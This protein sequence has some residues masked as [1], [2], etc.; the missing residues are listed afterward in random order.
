METEI[1]EQPKKRFTFREVHQ[2]LELESDF[3]KQHRD[4]RAFKEK[5][6]FL[7]GIGFGNSIATQ[8]YLGLSENEE[9]IR[10]ISA[11]YNGMYKFIIEPQ[12]KRLC[13]KYNLYVRPAW[14]FI[15]DIPEWNLKEMQLFKVD[16]FDLVPEQAALQIKNNMWLGT[17]INE[18][19]SRLNYSDSRFL[20]EKPKVMLSLLEVADLG[21]T[22]GNRIEIAAVPS[23]FSESGELIKEPRILETVEGNAKG[24]V[25]LD[26][27]V[28]VTLNNGGRLIVTAWG[29]EANDEIVMNPKQN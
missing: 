14:R 4:V 25:D 13:E 21:R 17:R 10:A 3:L 1:L 6:N 12:L 26:P 24:A 15:G 18:V 19:F 22:I 28:M 7:Q 5:G 20:Q 8:M 16:L 29:D 23:L 27:I 2:D 9:M 11:K